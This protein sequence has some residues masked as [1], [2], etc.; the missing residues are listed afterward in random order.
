MSE[1]IRCKNSRSMDIL[2]AAKYHY[3]VPTLEGRQRTPIVMAVIAIHN[4]L[5]KISKADAIQVLMNE[6]ENVMFRNPYIVSMMVRDMIRFNQFPYPQ[7]TPAQFV[8]IM[9]DGLVSALGMTSMP[10]L[11]EAKIEVWEP[12]GEK[13]D[14][15]VV[16]ELNRRLAGVAEASNV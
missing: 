3:R 1:Y 2:L 7:D 16:A 6:F 14:P 15:Q 13:L 9:L 10:D 11:R 5:D 12:G 8:D 4:G